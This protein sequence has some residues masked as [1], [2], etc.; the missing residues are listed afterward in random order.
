MDAEDIDYHYPTSRPQMEAEDLNYISD[1]S[2]DFYSS[3][4]FR[5]S[6]RSKSTY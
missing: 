4:T 2:S 5:L 6:K 3:N 1:D